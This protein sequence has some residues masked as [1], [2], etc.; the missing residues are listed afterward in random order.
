MTTSLTS[1]ITPGPQHTVALLPGTNFSY[2]GNR[3]SISTDTE[4]DRWYIGSFSS[5]SYFITVE[6]DSNRKETMQ[7][8]VIARAEAVNLSIFGRVSLPKLINLSATVNDSWVS[9]IANPISEVFKGARISFTA[10]YGQTMSQPIAPTAIAVIVP[11]SGCTLNISVTSNLYTITGVNQGG[12]G[13]ST[14]NYLKVLGPYLGGTTPANDVYVIVDTVTNGAVTSVQYVTGTGTGTGTFTNLP[15][16]DG[17]TGAGIT[18][19]TTVTLTTT[20]TLE[21]KT[22]LNPNIS[23]RI[24]FKTTGG[25]GVV[26][27]LTTSTNIDKTVTIPNTTGTLL[28]T[29]DVGTV[30]N[31]MLAGSIA[32]SKLVNSK[33]TINGTQINLGDS[34]DLAIQ[35]LSFG[36]YLTSSNGNAITAGTYNGTN[37]LTIAVNATP[38][39]IPSTV[40][41]RDANGNTSTNILTASQALTTTLST[42]SYTTTGSMIGTWQLGTGSTLQATW[43]D[44]AEKYSADADYKPGTV[45]EFGG[46]HEVTIAEDSTRRVAGV[47]STNPAYVMNIECAGDH[48]VTIAMTGRVPCKVRGKIQKGD[49]MV[50]AGSGYARAEFNPIYG[51]VIGKALED[52]DGIE[53]TIEVVVGKL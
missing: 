3:V 33:I 7:V 18:A 28:T 45:L 27:L 41:A 35:S 17:S 13:Y 46:K 52:F 44:L 31:T 8:L 53:G 32:N 5:A 2:M 1:Y 29:G 20:Q 11:G 23:D 40:M 14:G 21:N 9:I 24:Y 42:G 51:S 22:L 48:V 19:N 26:S 50:S 25:V 43:A 16:V 12:T 15:T 34:V 30:T 39:N 6:F 36:N 49:M 37:S 4:I 47:V 38:S 10:T